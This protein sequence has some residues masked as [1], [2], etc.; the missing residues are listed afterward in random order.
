LGATAAPAP[1]T[2]SQAFDATKCFNEKGAPFAR[3]A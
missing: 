3:R 1:V 2:P